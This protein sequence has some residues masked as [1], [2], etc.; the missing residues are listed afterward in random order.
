MAPRTA[1][2]TTKANTAE[3]FTSKINE[4]AQTA[5]EKVQEGVEAARDNTTEAIG[6]ARSSMEAAGAGLRD[7][8]L[9]VIDMVQA[10]ANALFE[11]IRKVA[12]AKSVQEAFE[13]Q[14]GYLR[15]QFQTSVKNARTVGEL[16]VE[17]AKDA[18]KP[19]RENLSKF[20]KA[21]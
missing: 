9:K 8:N 3:A 13:I 2:K 4:T 20:S 7:V 15:N 5:W 11:T 17:A 1:K 18:F 12:G 6:A 14:T 16:T 10:D 21:A 19:V